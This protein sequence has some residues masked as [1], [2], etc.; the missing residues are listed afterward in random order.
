MPCFKDI[1]GWYVAINPMLDFVTMAPKNMDGYYNQLLVIMN[2][3]KL[4]P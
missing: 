3:I 2:S 1:F 4:L